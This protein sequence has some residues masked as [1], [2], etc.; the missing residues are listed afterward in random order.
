MSSA[1]DLRRVR[2]LCRC[3]QEAFR[4]RARHQVGGISYAA[5]F[6]DIAQT[7]IRQPCVQVDP[8]GCLPQSRRA[9]LLSLAALLTLPL[10]QQRAAWSAPVQ[11]VRRLQCLAISGQGTA[12]LVKPQVFVAG[13]SG[14]SGRQ[15]VEQ[16]LKRGLAVRAGV[17]VCAVFHY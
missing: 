10:A 11:K 14:G 9:Q 17:R 3:T 7:F 2:L 1:L 5:Y 6:S 12:T 4:T 8:S 15:A 16:A 13:A